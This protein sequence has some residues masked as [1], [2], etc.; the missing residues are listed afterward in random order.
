MCTKMIE[1]Q[2]THQESK[3]LLKLTPSKAYY[4]DGWWMERRDYDRINFGK[5]SLGKGIEVS[6]KDYAVLNRDEETR[7]I[8]YSYLPLP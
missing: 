1:T 5:I 7:Q 8:T 2:I 6:V 3:K 4:E